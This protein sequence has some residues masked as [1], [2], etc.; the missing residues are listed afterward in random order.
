MPS[1][2]FWPETTTLFDIFEKN[3]IDARFVGGCVRDALL[4]LKTG[5]VDIAIAAPIGEVIKLLENSNL[6][7]IKTGVKYFSVKIVMND[8]TFDVT[9]LRKDVLCFGR[10]CQVSEAKTFEE[11]A[12]R[13][14]FAI[15]AVY[16]NIEGRIFDYFNGVDD[17]RNK[18]VIFIGNPQKRIEEDNLRILRYYRFCSFLSDYSGRYSEILKT[19]AHLVSTLSIIRIRKE[20][21]K[22]IPSKQIFDMMRKDCIPDHFKN[23]DEDGFYFSQMP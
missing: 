14:D 21:S 23:F 1:F 9:S 3:G 5:D 4:G 7:C 15:N 17:I 12:I 20:L 16:I 19:N 13:R 11:D 18:R 22:M 6:R 10:F 8:K 2:L